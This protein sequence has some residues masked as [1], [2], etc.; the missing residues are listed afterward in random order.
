[1]S[2]RARLTP[3]K[4][5]L[6]ELATGRRY[7][8][9]ELN[10]RANRAA[11][12]LW[13]QGVRPSD[14]VSILAHN[15]VVYLDLLYGCGKIGAVFAP[16]NWRLVAAELAY[17]VQDCAPRLLLF[18]PAFAETAVA[19]QSDLPEGKL[20]SLAEFESEAG[21][22]P[23]AEPPRPSGLNGESPYCI[24]YTSGTTGK[25]K[26]AVIP[27]RQVLWNCVNTAVSWELT[28]SDVTPVFTPMFHTGGLFAFLAPIHYAG[29]RVA[30]ARQFDAD[31]SLQ[32]IQE[33]GCTVILGVP[34]LFQMWQ[35]SPL[36]PDADFSRVR[37]FISGGAPCPVSLIRQWREAT[38]VVFRQGY[39]LTEV[40]PNCFSMTD[41]ESVAK[42]GT[43]GKPALHSRMRLV[44]ENGRDVPTG[45]TG[46]L[47]I[48]GPHVCAG[49]WHNP[50]ATAVS[51][52]D[53][54]FHTGDM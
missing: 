44:D 28:S 45:Q 51:L 2:G 5:A 23:A 16:L 12:W 49:Y 18:G 42:A 38:G 54:W 13:E 1:M 24:L 21:T 50:E 47:L 41:E 35:K 7:S 10:K 27:H 17:I 40:G 53:G 29:G 20:V 19:L 36:F 9:A 15:S 30:L 26:G 46:E 39:G 8:F 48:K 32:V 34:T 25:P 31:A 11:N 14:R 37:F 4:E 52:V 43:V 22:R 3:D 33:E 6:L